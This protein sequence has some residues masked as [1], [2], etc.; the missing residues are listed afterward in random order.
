M[1][2]LRATG[3]SLLVA[4][5]ADPVMICNMMGDAQLETV[6]RHYFA[7]HID[8]MQTAVNRLSIASFEL[9]VE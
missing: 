3:A 9:P 1:Y 4:C 2:V 8:H 7:S 5:G 6:R